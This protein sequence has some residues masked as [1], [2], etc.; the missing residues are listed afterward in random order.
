MKLASLEHGRDGRLVVVSTDL[1]RCLPADDVAATLQAALDDWTGK[2]PQLE[3]LATRVNAGEGGPFDQA[4]PRLSGQVVAAGAALEVDLGEAS[5]RARVPPCPVGVV[6]ILG[7]ARCP[8][9]LA[10]DEVIIDVE[11][12]TVAIAWRKIVQYEYVR[13][14]ERRAVVAEVAA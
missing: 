1:E 14:Q 13:H 6:W 2:R 7:D 4:H 5:L 12:R 8:R 11:A 9:E 3:D 10:V